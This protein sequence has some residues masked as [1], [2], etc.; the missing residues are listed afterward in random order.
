MEHV[1]GE[2]FRALFHGDMESQG[3]MLSHMLQFLV[4]AMSRPETMRLGLH[5]LGRR[6]VGYG[7]APEYYPIFRR[8]FLESV[9][10]VLGEKHTP[11][12]D[13]AWSD[14]IDMIIEAMVGPVFR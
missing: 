5:E 1:V 9:R 10:A 3:Q 2:F 7:V 6:H 4:Y 14:T 8:A 12:V 11:H 13:K